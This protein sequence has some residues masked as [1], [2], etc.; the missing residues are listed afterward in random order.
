MIRLYGAN[1]AYNVINK[2]LLLA[3]PHP[4]LEPWIPNWQKGRPLHV[5]SVGLCCSGMFRAF[6]ITGVNLAS[7]SV[8]AILCWVCGLIRWPGRMSLDFYLCLSCS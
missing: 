1:I 8:C 3:H 7:S 5:C 2:R 6:E 4:L